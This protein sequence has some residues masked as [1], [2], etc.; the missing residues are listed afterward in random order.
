MESRFFNVG[1]MRG[2]PEHDNPLSLS[3]LILYMETCLQGRVSF[4]L[5]LVISSRKPSC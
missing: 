3:V 2:T 5:F 4:N 1:W